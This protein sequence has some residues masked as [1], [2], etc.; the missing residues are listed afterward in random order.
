MSSTNIHCN[1]KVQTWGQKFKSTNFFFDLP[2]SDKLA[3][4]PNSAVSF[5]HCV[6]F[7]TDSNLCIGSLHNSA[8]LGTPQGGLATWDGICTVL[9]WMV[10]GG[11]AMWCMVCTIGGLGRLRGGLPYLCWCWGP[12]WGVKYLGLYPGTL[13]MHLLGSCCAPNVL[14]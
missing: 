6:D 4:C 11:G 10:W 3:C 13:G 7:D 9:A 2:S 5:S 12:R 8:M 1:I 14:L